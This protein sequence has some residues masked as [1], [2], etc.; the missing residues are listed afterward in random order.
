MRLNFK[1]N[2]LALSIVSISFILFNN[3]SAS[4]QNASVKDVLLQKYM[5]NYESK[6]QLEDLK[7]VTLLNGGKSVD[8][9]IEVMKNG[10]YP[11]KNRWIA[12]F[13]L[14]EIMGKKSS[15]FISK[16]LIHPSWVM[17][18]ASLKTL[19]ALKE[20]RYIPQYTALLNDDSLLVRE[21]ALENIRELKI[22]AAAPEVWAMLYDKRNYS[23][24]TINGKKLAHKRTNIIKEVILTI[25][26]LKFEKA[27]EPL[28]KMIQKNRYNDI[29]P[30]MDL[31]LSKITGETSPT[32]DLK[33]KRNFWHK[34]EMGSIIQ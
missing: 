19:L 12:T 31:A 33:A 18:M 5:S 32:A 26:E 25:G 29:F 3:S 16:F 27:K 17:R 14:G 13:M 2:I 20:S 34:S 22:S 24:P 15:P 9:L 21:Q 6:Q 7:K 4:I 10:K 11:D 23:V 1:R 8:A 28:L 30:E